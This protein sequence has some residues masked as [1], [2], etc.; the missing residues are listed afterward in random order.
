MRSK[1]LTREPSA[2]SLLLAGLFVGVCAWGLA[3]L[4]PLAT[5]A[6]DTTPQGQFFRTHKSQFAPLYALLSVQGEMRGL[7]LLL[8]GCMLYTVLAAL[9]WKILLPMRQQ[10]TTVTWLWHS[11]LHWLLLALTWAGWLAAYP[12]LSDDASDYLVQ[13]R[14]V[15]HYGVNPYLPSAQELLDND[16]WQ[17]TMSSSAHR[18]ALTYG[19]VWLYLSLPIVALAGS[20]LPLA[21]I[22]LKLL[23]VVLLLV[24]GAAL[25]R[26]LTDDEPHQ[27]RLLLLLLA[28]HP[29]LWLEVPWNGHNDVAMVVWVVLALLAMQHNRPLITAGLL[30]G[31]VATKYIPCA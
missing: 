2:R 13:A 1:A 9:Y 11:R 10:Q 8:A 16:A 31:G 4:V 26:L 3:L 25:W 14:L 21:F 27:R 20:S 12:L 30:M 23:N 6:S 15:V 28:W 24:C 19:P 17:Q 7:L 18:S 22:G 5:Y 29:L